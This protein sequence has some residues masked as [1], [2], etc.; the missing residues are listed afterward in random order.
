ME[1]LLLDGPF[2]ASA[3]P[4]EFAFHV[5]IEA[6][7]DWKAI[8][9]IVVKP[10]GGIYPVLVMAGVHGTK[11]NV[12]AATQ[13]VRIAFTG[14]EFLSGFYA[15][16]N[17]IDHAVPKIRWLIENDN[18]RMLVVIEKRWNKTTHRHHRLGEAPR[19]SRTSHAHR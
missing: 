15:V 5:W 7:K 6:L 8:G 9:I 12:K 1:W 3:L 17:G 2:L 16:S 13:D 10:A 4:G 18:F 11:L 19:S 14:L